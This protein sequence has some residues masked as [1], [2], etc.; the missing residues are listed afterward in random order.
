MQ[1][2]LICQ[3]FAELDPLPKQGKNLVKQIHLS[4]IP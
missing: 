3:D 4:S 1:A 2:E